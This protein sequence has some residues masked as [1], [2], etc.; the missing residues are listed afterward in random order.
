[1][2]YLDLCSCVPANL[3]SP[4]NVH[5]EL[6]SC[7]GCSG[8]SHPVPGPHLLPGLPSLCLPPAQK[9]P[10]DCPSSTSSS[11]LTCPDQHKPTCSGCRSG[12]YW[13]SFFPS[14]HKC[15]LRHTC[16]TQ[17]LCRCR[18]QRLGLDCTV[19]AHAHQYKH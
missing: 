13:L 9:L 11:A 4:Y 17:D 14:S 8:S 5:W 2:G 12:V 1:M 10:W 19:N 3:I 6:G 15:A 18:G 16:K 7:L